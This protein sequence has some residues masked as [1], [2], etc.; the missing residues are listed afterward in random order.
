M[1]PL[2]HCLISS[3]RPPQVEQGLLS[4]YVSPVQVPFRH[5]VFGRGP[6]TL[7]SLGGLSDPDELHTQLALATWTLQGCADGLV[8]DVWELD[9]EI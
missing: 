5:V 1:P 6:H 4:P 3:L 8:G 2:I 9:N 7:G